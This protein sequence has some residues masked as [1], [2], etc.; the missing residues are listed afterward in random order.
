MRNLLRS[1]IVLC[2]I[3]SVL[4]CRKEAVAGPCAQEPESPAALFFDNLARIVAATDV[5]GRDAGFYLANEDDYPALAKL[6]ALKICLRDGSTASYFDLP[7]AQKPAFLRQY[8]HFQAELLEEKFR[9]APALEQYI[10]AQNDIVADALAGHSTKA[11]DLVIQ[12]PKSFYSDL[13]SR[14]DDFSG[15]FVPQEDAPRTRSNYVWEEVEYGT[16]RSALDG[17]ARRGDIIVAL[18]VH[19]KPLMVFD[20]LRETGKVGHAE[21]FTKDVTSATTDTEAI[22][23]GA[24]RPEG[25]IRNYIPSWRRK[26][27]LAGICTF[28]MEWMHDGCG[29]GLNIIREPLQDPSPLADWAEKYEGLEYLYWYEHLTAKWIAPVRFTCTTLIWWCAKYAFD[30]RLSS[31]LSPLVLPIDL[32]VD[33]NTY[34]KSVIE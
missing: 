26:S 8:M 19:D 33:S 3:L 16:V 21:V 12:D 20:L 9:R 23:L 1:V 32:L 10:S 15:S 22:S 5:E 25:V 34:F 18:P 27:Y 7:A 11:G 29:Y 2:V 17:K 31:W 6:A 28:K 14:I 4:S 30:I 24:R 13:R